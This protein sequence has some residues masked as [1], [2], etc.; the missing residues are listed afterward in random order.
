MVCCFVLQLEKVLQQGDIGDCCEPYM[1][2]KE[3]D[4]SKVTSLLKGFIGCRSGTEVAVHVHVRLCVCMCYVWARQALLNSV[5]TAAIF[6]VLFIFD[7]T[8]CPLGLIRCL[9]YNCHFQSGRNAL[10]WFTGH[11]LS[12]FCSWKFLFLHHR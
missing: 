3:S 6:A 5:S 9:L 1:I 4:S 11:F 10:M 8:I 2:M 7:R 12:C